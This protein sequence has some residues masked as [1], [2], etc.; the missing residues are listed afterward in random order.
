MF[1]SLLDT[2]KSAI[3]RRPRS[4]IIC[5]LI[6]I[7]LVQIH[8]ATKPYP[9]P[10]QVL[11]LSDT[12]TQPDSQNLPEPPPPQS[13]QLSNIPFPAPW[14]GPVVPVVIPPGPVPAF[15]KLPISEPVVFLGIDDGWY[16]SPEN[17]KWLKKHHL[18]FSLFLVNSQ[19]SGDSGYFKQLQTAGMT[20]EDHSATHPDFIKLNE[21]DQQNQI[22][23]TANNYFDSFGRRP[24]L[25]RPPYGDYNDQTRQAAAAC[26]VKALVL[27][28]VVLQDGTIQYQTPATRLEPG[29]IILA[30]FQN[31]LIPNMQALSAELEH[32]H[33]QLGRLEDW[34]R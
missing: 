7:C 27:W 16:Q 4:I 28:H 30:H 19:I 17:L 23:N 11:T 33:L 34:L 3:Q 20:I 14:Q 18:P 22:C 29:D 2:I 9:R 21:A 26:D 10:Q 6:V 32:D 5:L 13:S 25:F 1:W 24:T 31:D 8:T 12:R 15:Y